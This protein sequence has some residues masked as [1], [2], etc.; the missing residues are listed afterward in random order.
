MAALPMHPR[1][2]ETSLDDE[3][4]GALHHPRADGP[5]LVSKLRVVH[6]G[7]SLAQVVQMLLDALA[8]GQFAPQLICHVQKRT[9][10]SVFEDVETPF[11]HP[12]RNGQARF[13]DSIEHLA[14]MFGGMGKIQNT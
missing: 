12:S 4:V 2:F 7:L 14:H 6:Q 13:L 1:S 11:E 5:A 8:L 3:F 9:R 10:P